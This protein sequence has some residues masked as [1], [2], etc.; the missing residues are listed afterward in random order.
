MD[1]TRAS[2][3]DFEDLFA[4]MTEAFP[5][6][7][8]RPKERQ[9]ALFGDERYIVYV[10]KENG[11]THGFLALWRLTGFYFAEHFAICASERNRRL[12]SRFLEQVL[13]G[14]DLPLVLEAE[15]R[16]DDISR[17]RMAFYERN[18]FT[19]TDVSYDQPNFHKSDKRIPLRLMYANLQDKAALPPFKEVIFKDIY[20]QAE[21]VL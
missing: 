12:G 8:Y 2:I 11:C 1:I 7:E 16:G 19:L 13:Q 3:E 6:E 4:I 14:L 15:D 5:P 18:G 20:K 10:L 21:S 17:R 9:K